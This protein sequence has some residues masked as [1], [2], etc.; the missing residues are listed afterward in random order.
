MNY[1]ELYCVV[2]LGNLPLASQASFWAK[3]R[4]W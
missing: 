3:V 4:E 2:V 1:I